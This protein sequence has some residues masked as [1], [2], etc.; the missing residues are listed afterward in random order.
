MKNL[1]VVAVAVLLFLGAGQAVVAQ[2]SSVQ[3]K[4]ISATP[5]MLVIQSASGERM[6]FTVNQQTSMPPAPTLTNGTWVTVEYSGQ[7]ESGSQA[8]RVTTSSAPSAS[9]QGGEQGSQLPGTA[10][11]LPLLLLIGSGSL[12]GYSVLRMR[13]R[14]SR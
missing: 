6:T 7:I 11:P 8:T 3:G 1:F 5:D 9:E 13:A 4:V 2:S 12:G 10:S 14:L